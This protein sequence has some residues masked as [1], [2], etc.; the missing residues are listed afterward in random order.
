MSE[1]LGVVC[2]LFCNE[3]VLEALLGSQQRALNRAQTDYKPFSMLCWVNFELLT[4]ALNL[5][6]TIEFRVV[7]RT[8]LL[9]VVTI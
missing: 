4:E 9:L 2:C 7:C 1:I 3:A 6:F 5:M 8:L